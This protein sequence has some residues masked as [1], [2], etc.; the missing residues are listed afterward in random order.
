MVSSV[1]D[2]QIDS[3]LL[4]SDEYLDARFMGVAARK[5]QISG[6]S[7]YLLNQENLTTTYGY[8][9]MKIAVVDIQNLREWLSQILNDLS[10]TDFVG[11][12]RME[13]LLWKKYTRS[14]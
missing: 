8:V 14:S 12:L 4:G 13:K 3:T 9:S 6:K 2:M 7:I 5:L 11:K 10:Y 1:S